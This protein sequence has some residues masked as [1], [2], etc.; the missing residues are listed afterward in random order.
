MKHLFKYSSVF[1]LATLLVGAVSWWR[2]STRMLEASF[3]LYLIASAIF[4][5]SACLLVLRRYKINPSQDILMRFTALLGAIF[6]ITV[7]LAIVYPF[8][9]L[10]NA[11]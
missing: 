9:R 4:A 7:W 5:V 2:D 11:P 8:V 10:I 1:L 3:W 6:C